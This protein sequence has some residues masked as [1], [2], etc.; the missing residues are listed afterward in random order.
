MAQVDMFKALGYGL[1]CGLPWMWPCHG[2]RSCQH[3]LVL[4]WGQGQLFVTA[5]GQPPLL[6]PSPSERSRHQTELRLLKKTNEPK[7]RDKALA[8]QPHSFRP[9]S[10]V[11]AATVTLWPVRSGCRRPKTAACRHRVCSE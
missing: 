7:H 4:I 9:L 2:R 5:S 3:R 1:R 6:A 10:E 11:P 8:A